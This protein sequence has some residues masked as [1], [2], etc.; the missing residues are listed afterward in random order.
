MSGCHLTN[1]SETKLE[2]LLQD[3]QDK[4]DKTHLVDPTA[5]VENELSNPT[6][7]NEDFP[8]QKPQVSLPTEDQ[9]SVTQAEDLLSTTVSQP[10]ENGLWP[11]LHQT[12]S[13]VLDTKR[14][15]YLARHY[16]HTRWKHRALESV[17]TKSRQESIEIL[18]AGLQSEEEVIAVTA[19]IGLSRLGIH[20]SKKLLSE[21]V[22]NDQLNLMLRCAALEAYGVGCQME[23]DTKTISLLFD[24]MS[25]SGS[26][27]L[28]SELYTGLSYFV[29]ARED[30]RFITGLAD[31]RP[32][33]R[34]TILD[35]MYSDFQHQ[36]PSTSI[37]LLQDVSPMVVHASIRTAAPLDQLL[38]L[39]NSPVYQEK[40]DALF[41]LAREQSDE[42]LQA[43][44]KISS[45]DSILVQVA[46]LKAA[47]I[48]QQYAYCRDQVENSQWRVRVA[49][50]ESMDQPSFLDLGDLAPL[51]LID[52]SIQV[53]DAMV[54]SMQNWESQD[55]G[56]KYLETIKAE[57]ATTTLQGILIVEMQNKLGIEISKPKTDKEREEMIR[58]LSHLAQDRWDLKLSIPGKTEMPERE[59]V[60]SDEDAAMIFSLI[61]KHEQ[62]S[63][64]S[65]DLVYQRQLIQLDQTLLQLLAQYASELQQVSLQKLYTN[66]LPEIDEQ[67]ARL[68]E[69]E[70]DDLTVRRDVVRY[71]QKQDRQRPLHPLLL[72]K[73]VELIQLSE[74]GDQ[75]LML[76]DILEDDP[77]ASAYQAVELA[78]HH[79]HPMVR[80][81][82][83]IHAGTYIHSPHAGKLIALLHDVDRN[84]RYESTRALGNYNLPQV[85]EPLKQHL[86]SEDVQLRL[87]AATSLAQQ[88]DPA[89]HD[90]LQRLVLHDSEHTRRNAIRVMVEIADPLYLDAMIRLLDDQT[91]IRNL[92]LQGLP[93][94]VGK[95]ISLEE[96]DVYVS[97]DRRVAL[98]RKW[99][100]QRVEETVSAYR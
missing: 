85:L 71:Y 64:S 16:A 41:G 87:I 68:V 28:K 93:K 18:E 81:K 13:W 1:P 84:V 79:E 83:C 88:N 78:L 53:R 70:S 32:N 99:Y 37:K 61:E 73:L 10:N 31:K 96:E 46:A 90:A 89:G 47:A 98:W 14:P 60:L 86:A 3:K 29:S 35:L 95:D 48:A 7:L 49:L 55:A 77:S 72:S 43:I 25:S 97:S 8:A 38:K 27:L 39:L 17:L 26:E 52:K 51:L 80:R 57:G 34:A 92:A 67:F 65:L 6:N 45:V 56:Q 11:V 24:A 69:F 63:D 94:I 4:Q 59:I 33:I 2:S 23:D 5:S 44:R 82:A 21:A 40:A 12:N 19:A 36:L 22:Q 54:E 20:E 91:G 50:A 66:I 100:Y 75:W 74:P 76:M 42:G 15:L 62:A 58:S 30:A 9:F